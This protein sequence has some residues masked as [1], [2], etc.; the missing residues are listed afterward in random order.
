MITSYGWKDYTQPSDQN[1]KYGY[2]IDY[3]P[4]NALSV[5]IAPTFYIF[6]KNSSE[7]KGGIYA[8]LGLGY[9]AWKVS[10]TGTSLAPVSDSAYYTYSENFGSK[11]FSGLISI[12]GDRKLGP[13]RIYFEIP[14][15]LDIYGT[16][17]TNYTSQK[18]NNNNIIQPDYKYSG[19][20]QFDFRLFL[21]LGYQLYF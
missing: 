11:N 14:V 5:M 21:N 4:G 8:S 7:S 9:S 6:G 16:N 20:Q 10:E 18:W 13:G 3:Q 17:F 15:V 19:F 2:K 1:F 12:G